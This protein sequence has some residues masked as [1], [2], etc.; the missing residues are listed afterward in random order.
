MKDRQ[1]HWEHLYATQPPETVGWYRPHLDTSLAFIQALRLPL[2]ARILDV[3]GG[4]STLVDD[5]LA[6]GFEAITV[7]DLSAT[8]LAQAQAR[9]GQQAERVT[10]I[11]ADITKV[12]LPAA[13]Y[14]LWHDRAV[15]HF[16]TTP[17]ERARYL[18]QLRAAL[19]PGGFVILATFAPE[20]PPRC[21]GL[22]VVRYDLDT[23]VRTVGPGFRLVRHGREHHVTPGGVEQPYLYVCFQR[24]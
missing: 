4:A 12:S 2:T 13:A 11:V 24:E 1:A 20:A 5:L 14:D 16:L 6:R 7:L 18:K 3:G 9:L 19:R 10:W 22:P 15:F 8:A 17:E 23:L 21:S